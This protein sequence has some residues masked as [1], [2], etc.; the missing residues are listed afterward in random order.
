MM[1]GRLLTGSLTEGFVFR[2][3]AD[4]RV[5]A[6]VEDEELVSSAGIEA[7]GPR[8]RLLVANADRSERTDCSEADPSAANNSRSHP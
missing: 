2:I 8:D 7:G 5:E 6:L 1:N 4:G 3:H